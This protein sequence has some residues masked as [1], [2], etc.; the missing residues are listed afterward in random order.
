MIELQTDTMVSRKVFLGGSWV[1]TEE[2]IDVFDPANGQAFARVHTIGRGHV[3]GALKTAAA[4]LPVWR[5]L[6]AKERGALL[7]RVADELNRRKNEIARII[8]QENGKPLAQSEGEVAMA[9]DHLRW[10]A[11]EGRRVYGRMIPPQA[12]GKRHLVVKTPIGVVGAIAPWNFPLVLSVRKVAPALAAGCPVILKPASQTPLSA[13]ALAECM[14]SAG[15]PSGV[16]QLAIGNAA[17]IAEE[18]LTNDTCRKIS[19]TG[20]T[21]TGQELIRG[22]AKSIKPLCLE[23]GGHAPLLVFDDCDLDR[24]V[25]EAIIAKFRN[26]GQSC[27]AAN[28]IYVQKTIY[29]DFVQRF[30]AAAKALKVGPGLEPGMDVGPMISQ[31]A[32]DGALAQ[33]RDAEMHGGR[34][35]VGGKRLAGHSGYF[36]EPT[37]I[38]GVGDEALCMNE[39][40]FA[41]IAPITSFETEEEAVRRANATPYGL[42]AYAMT[43]DIGRIFRLAESIEAGTLGIND[44]APSTSQSPFGGVKQSG[45]GRELGIEG[46]EA[47]LETKHVSIGGI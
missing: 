1:A 35:L 31:H 16:F 33:L 32:L 8:T 21:R 36:L 38:E 11:E 13:I 46:L 41:P 20:S 39:E 19:F 5:G 30:V 25:Q 12:K 45:W 40:T 10:F 23:L 26:T 17:M 4:V 3:H 22:A 6:T 15:M 28:R 43:R 44:G 14:E 29:N 7:N 34:V 9:E 24:A 37:V 42:S 47:F 18:F 2:A 27:I